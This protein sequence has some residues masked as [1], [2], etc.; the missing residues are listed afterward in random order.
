[1]ATLET[2]LT[3]PKKKAAPA[4]PTTRTLRKL[5]RAGWCDSHG[6][7]IARKD[8]TGRWWITN[9]YVLRGFD[10]GPVWDA[11]EHLANDHTDGPLDGFTVNVAASG[12]PAH[13]FYSTTPPEF[14]TVLE[15]ARTIRGFSIT[16]WED[17]EPHGKD[18]TVIGT[19][20]FGTSVRLN[21]KYLRALLDGVVDRAA[22]VVET[23]T[24]PVGAWVDG[25]LVG[26]LMPVRR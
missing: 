12:T 13:S 23:D 1:M 17:G 15:R 16:S 10:D 6:R 8:E 9:T 14:A 7:L 21:R 24:R 2:V 22:I 19:A 18:D 25:E 11:M 26:V 5:K 4:D 3:A 20:E